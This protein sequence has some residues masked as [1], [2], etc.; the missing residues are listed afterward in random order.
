MSIIYFIICIC[1]AFVILVISIL[2]QNEQ[3]I[4]SEA[5]LRRCTE[6]DCFFNEDLICRSTSYTWN[7]EL[8]DN[9]PDYTED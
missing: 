1:L 9:C 7:P 4:R 8:L 2:I 5:D 3:R 6:T